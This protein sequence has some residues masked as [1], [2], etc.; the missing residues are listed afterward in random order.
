MLK[1]LS[2]PARAIVH[3]VMSFAMPST[4]KIVTPRL[5][6]CTQGVIAFFH[7]NA[8]GGGGGERV[9][10]CAS[11]VCMNSQRVSYGNKWTLDTTE[12]LKPHT[13][14]LSVY[15]LPCSD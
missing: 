2:G 12:V 10:W 9:L 14:Q 5:G 4:N 13:G 1:C 15:M 11:V 7:P 6:L 3:C 8:N